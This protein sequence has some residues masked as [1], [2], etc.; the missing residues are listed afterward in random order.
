MATKKKTVKKQTKKTVAIAKSPTVK[1][2][3]QGKRAYQTSPENVVQGGITEEYAQGNKMVTIRAGE[4]C[5][6]KRAYA[7]Q[8][9]KL[10]PN[11][12]ILIE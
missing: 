11:E 1:I 10:Y 2:W 5:L 8:M 6:V 12:I 7:E 4:K 3:N 9:A